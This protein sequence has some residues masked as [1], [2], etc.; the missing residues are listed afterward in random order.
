MDVA[1][2]SRLAC[3]AAVAVAAIATLNVRAAQAADVSAQLDYS[4]APGCPAADDF[5]AVVVGRLGFS[6]F[7]VDASEQV[8]VR[9]EPA[10]K[11]L[12]GRIE[13]RDAAGEWIG[14]QKFPSRT[15]DCG[16]LA[17]AMGFALALQ[18][19][20]MATT[21]AEARPPAADVAEPQPT[22]VPPP[23]PTVQ[24][25][26]P[27][28]AGPGDTSKPDLQSSGP[29]IIVGAGGAV[30]LGVSSSPVPLGRLFA[31]VAWSRTAVELAAE[32][33]APSTTQQADGAGFSQQQW[34]ASLAGCGVVPPLNAC[35]VAKIGDIRVTGQGVD[36]PAT[37]H[38]FVAQAGLRLGVTHMLG[39]RVQLGAH[40][41]GLALTTQGTVTLDGLP[42]WTTPRFAAQLGADIGVRFR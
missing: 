28:T 27:P 24:T 7:R 12:A 42:V 22:A 30:G 37:A 41:D 25:A 4:A 26:A 1:R 29:S 35:L 31:A 13:W 40:A 15:G 23:P 5:E 17:R 9:I 36:F 18:I 3:A 32:I 14:E 38:G 21:T 11:A 19:Q 8:I 39:S 16:E 6:P 10:G 33:S 2:T 20:L 34:L